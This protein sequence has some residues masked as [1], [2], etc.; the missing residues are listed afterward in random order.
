MNTII[1]RGDFYI[2]IF[3]QNKTFASISFIGGFNR[4]AFGH[5][6][7]IAICNIDRIFAANTIV[8]RS[9]IISAVIKFEIILAYYCILVIR[10]KRERTFS[11][12]G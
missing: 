8:C 5:D 11:T 7:E 12:K 2:A 10:R 6:I 3:D 9:N 4:I 1:A